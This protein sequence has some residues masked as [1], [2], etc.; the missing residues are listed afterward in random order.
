VGVTDQCVM[1]VKSKSCVGFY[2]LILVFVDLYAE[3]VKVRFHLLPNCETKIA[4]SCN[5]AL[6]C[7]F[8]ILSKHL[9]PTLT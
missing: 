4:H 6:I 3:M 2:I 1:N 9:T 5:S 7:Q 8:P